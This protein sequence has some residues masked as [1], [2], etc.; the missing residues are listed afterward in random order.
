MKPK[1]YI[2]VWLDIDYNITKEKT[3]SF[4]NLK[5]AKQHAKKLL[6]HA[7]DDTKTIKVIAL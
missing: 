4:D 3:Y 5:E 6:A 7:M 2:F 1:T